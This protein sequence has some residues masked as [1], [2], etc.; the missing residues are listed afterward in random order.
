M[1]GHR[2]RLS[3][4]AVASLKDRVPLASLISSSVVLQ[5]DGAEHTGLCPFHIEDTP[6]FRV[7]RDHAH[8]FGCGWHGDALDW[9][10]DQERMSFMGAV[11]H[12]REWSG[13]DEPTGTS[14][15]RPSPPVLPWRP[16]TPVP[17]NAPSLID[18]SG[19]AR[20]FNPKRAGT[21]WE[22]TRWRP[23]L[24][25]AYRNA[26]GEL[27]G[28]VLRVE[29]REGG[30][31][32]PTVTYC[33][34]AETGERRWCV[35]PFDVPR[36]LYGLDNLARRPTTVVLVEGE[37]TRDAARRLLPSLVTMTWPGGCRGYHLV[38]WTPLLGRRVVGIPDADKQGREAFDGRIDNHGR[39]VAG[40]LEILAG[41]GAD[42]RRVE[43]PSTFACGWDLADAEQQQW[44]TARTL[45]WIKANLMEPCRAAA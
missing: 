43:P 41:V 29:R 30:K 9:L 37:K 25:H 40:I 34:H 33:H 26:R 7:W 6:S 19:V 32:T 20:A 44:D 38:D 2:H 28:Y 21:N 24:D 39:R 22:W 4:E 27:I 15:P 14:N 45:A 10:R 13:I 11:R 36:P 31:F 42:A 5:K 23:T 1:S 35:V 8:C 18:Q 17:S 16:M 12:L 3:R